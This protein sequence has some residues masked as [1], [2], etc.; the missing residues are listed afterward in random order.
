MWWLANS[1]VGA[2]LCTSHFLQP[3]HSER[4]TLPY[5]VRCKP[6]SSSQCQ[7]WS[8]ADASPDESDSD[9]AKGE[10]VFHAQR[11]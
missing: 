6:I 9:V 8:V 11:S 7:P 4:R 5:P 2:L 10:I 3:G 1:V